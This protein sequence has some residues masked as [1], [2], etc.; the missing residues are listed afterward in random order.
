VFTITFDAVTAPF[1]IRVFMDDVEAP[2]IDLYG[3][4]KLIRIAEKAIT[5]L[6]H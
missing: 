3:P 2:D 4:K 6:D 5:K 1:R